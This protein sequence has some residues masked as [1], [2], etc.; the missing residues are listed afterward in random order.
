MDFLKEIL[1]DELF[2]Q[3]KQK[4]DAYNSDEANKEKQI[5]LANL[6]GGDYVS[7]GKYDA[8]QALLTGKEDELNTAN[9]LIKDLK[10]STVGN[11]DIQG[12]ITNYEGTIEN[13]QNQLEQTKIESAIKVAL[14]E[15]KALDIDYMTFK[16][17]EKGEIKLD[18]NGKIKGWKDTITSLKTQFPNQFESSATKKIDPNRLEGGDQEPNGMTKGEFLK[19]PY[20]ERAMF[21]QENPEAFKELMNQE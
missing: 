14:L 2:A 19:K 1:G 12:K 16:L 7:K 15:E 18:E 5:K 9:T 6:G 10:K 20:G 3:F 4:V 8:L 17:K 11:E 13:L 21:A